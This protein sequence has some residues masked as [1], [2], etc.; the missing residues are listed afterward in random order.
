M[1]C[2][3]MYRTHHLHPPVR[4]MLPAPELLAKEI[5][6]GVWRNTICLTKCPGT[7]KQFSHHN[8]RSECAWFSQC[9]IPCA[10]D[11]P[12]SSSSSLPFLPFSNLLGKNKHRLYC[13]GACRTLKAFITMQ[14][15]TAQTYK[16]ISIYSPCRLF[17]PHSPWTIQHL[18]EASWS[19][20]GMV[21]H[22]LYDHYFWEW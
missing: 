1:I 19:M 17:P 20:E 6:A 11:L 3:K 22:P 14:I 7:G 5:I 18:L 15:V 9:V 4:V 10:E 13:L 2:N 16:W 12:S 21:M 8:S